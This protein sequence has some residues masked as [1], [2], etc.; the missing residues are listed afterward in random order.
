MR[1][2]KQKEIG[3]GKPTKGGNHLP[4]ETEKPKG[5]TTRPQATVWKCRKGTGAHDRNRRKNLP[6]P[7]G[8]DHDNH[9]KQIKTTIWLRR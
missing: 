1:C 2:L 4:A 9:R 7:I 8:T 6:A 5:P 3:T